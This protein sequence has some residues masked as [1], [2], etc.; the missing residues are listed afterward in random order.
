MEVEER[1]LEERTHPDW[2]SRLP[3]KLHQVPLW[4]LA[5]PGSHDSMSFSLDMCS[6]LLRSQPA[7]FRLL[8]S[9]LPC[10]TRPC[11]HR[12][13]TTQQ[14]V[15]SIQCELG[16][17][18]L[19]L[20][21]AKKPGRSRKLF[22]AHGVYTLMTVKEALEELADWLDAHPRE[23]VIISCSHFESLTDSDHSDLVEYIIGL[24]GPKLCS[25]QERPT[26]SSCWLRGQQLIVSYDNKQMVQEH[27]QL[28]TSIPYWYADS[29]DP[30]K[31]IQ[32]LEEHQSTGRPVGLFVSGLNLTEDLAYILLHPCQNLRR[33]T[34][35]GLP[36]LLCWTNQQCPG[37]QEGGVN[38]LCS[39]FVDLSHF[40]SI[41]IG[42]NDKLLDSTAGTEMYAL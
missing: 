11:I 34:V 23:V 17:R 21:I 27:P 6:P 38:I 1:W 25:S 30:Q 39:D 12:W 16:I 8:D 37:P 19:D 42:L 24:F 4:D 36:L 40:C 13:S 31:V 2:M 15:L 14:S 29:P 35:K 10:C 18:F 7:L 26:L 22:F 9:L 33:M 20:R 28:W 3:Q 32:Y 41:V 5:I